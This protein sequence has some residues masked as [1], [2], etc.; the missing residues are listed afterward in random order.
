MWKW[1]KQIE[2]VDSSD[3]GSV[4]SRPSDPGAAE[5]RIAPD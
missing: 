4:A 5:Y 2:E 3:M 1:C